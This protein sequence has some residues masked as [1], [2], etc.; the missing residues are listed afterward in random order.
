MK[1]FRKAMVVAAA[2]VV[3][4]SAA[5]FAACGETSE[6]TDT[7]KVIKMWTHLSPET[8]E[9][10]VYQ[11][12]ADQFNEEG[13][14]TESGQKIEVRLEQKGNAGNL[15]TAIA[16]NRK[17]LPDIVTVD[18]PD[19]ANQVRT[20]ILT[21]IT[22][23]VSADEKADYVSTVIEQGTIGGKLYALSAMDAPTA[24]YYNKSI[25]TKTVLEAAG[26]GDYATLENPWTWDDLIKVMSYLKTSGATAEIKAAAGV[27]LNIGFGDNEGPMYLYSSLVYSAG[28]DFC[29]ESGKV[30]GHMDSDKALN[31]IR[32]LEPIF[33]DKYLNDGGQNADIFP[34]GGVA[35]EIHGPWEMNNIAKNYSSFQYGIMPMPVYNDNGKVVA[36]CGSWCMGVTSGAKNV[37]AAAEVVKYFTSAFASETFYNAIGTFP[38][39][40][41]SFNNLDDFKNDGP[42][43]TLSQIFTTAAVSR[44]RVEKYTKLRDAYHDLID[45]M[46]QQCGEGGDYGLK[47][48]ATELATRAQG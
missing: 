7:L 3:A 40:V 48:K 36:G 10:S 38:T 16:G 11:A 22:D 23:Y 20:R 33:R 35:F 17:S 25:V 8:P 45:F 1:G 18:S 31:G 29:D 39:H 26:V 19:I 47:D 14:E 6:D 4:V 27:K 15:S 2:A 28:G 24:L 46:Q 30:V 34:Q 42:Q 9:G 37:Q 44:P 5:G 32:M 41:S 21:D 12:L 13:H 43:K